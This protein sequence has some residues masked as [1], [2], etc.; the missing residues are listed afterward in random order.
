MQNNIRALTLVLLAA[1][2]LPLTAQKKVTYIDD[3]R[4]VLQRH[5]G[6][7]HNSDRKRADLDVTSYNTLM[8]GSSSGEVVQSG[9]PGDSTLYL[10]VSHQI[11]PFMPPKQ[12]RIPDKS[13]AIL[14]A[15]IEGGLLE[16]SGSKARAAKKTGANLALSAPVT[17]KPDGPPPGR[18]GP[19]ESW[20]VPRKTEKKINLD[21]GFWILDFGERKIILDSG[22]PITLTA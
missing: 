4:P 5:C 17:G 18:G 6:N 19:G 22:S 13:L 2:Q 16:T 1:V 20:G 3:V 15:W 10:L 11:E 8:A 9:E 7:C 12:P 14:K 21:S